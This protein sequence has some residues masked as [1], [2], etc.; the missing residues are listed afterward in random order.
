MLPQGHEYT[1][2]SSISTDGLRVWE[3][4]LSRGYELQYDKNGKLITNLVAI[5]GDA[6]VNELGIPVQKGEFE[7]IKVKSQEEFEIVKKALLPY[8]EKLGLNEND[9][10]WLTGTVKINLPV[11]KSTKETPQEKAVGENVEVVT[12]KE[13]EALRDV[14]STLTALGNLDIDWFDDFQNK[15]GEGI[16]SA[17]DVS[18]AYHK[19]KADGTN[20]ELVKAVES[21][22]SKE[23]TPSGIKEQEI[24][25]NTPDKVQE[26]VVET[27][28][29][30]KA[31]PT[32][33]PETKAAI[34][35]YNRLKENNDT[36][37]RKEY[38]A[39]PESCP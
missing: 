31:Q 30:L 20:P 11:L 35:V 3:Q 4:Q 16:K 33:T 36:T 34:D 10:R 18:E 26:E 6:I 8:L 29:T 24:K 23:Q 13:N 2:K 1:E 14:E 17:K 21:L 39:L 19:A 37:T 32:A 12:P 25:V 28:E 5:N 27:A 38:K 15:F 22:L 9:I 7:N